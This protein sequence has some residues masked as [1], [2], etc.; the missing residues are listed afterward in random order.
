MLEGE[1]MFLAENVHCF[2]ERTVESRR[3]SNVEAQVSIS[4]FLVTIGAAFVTVIELNL[5]SRIFLRI[6]ELAIGQITL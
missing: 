4:V 1:S 6:L 5:E 3:G 2:F